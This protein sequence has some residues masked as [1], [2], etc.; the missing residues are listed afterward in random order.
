MNAP[1]SSD[2]PAFQAAAQEN[3]PD[4]AGILRRVFL[5]LAIVAL[6]MMCAAVAINW[7]SVR[8]A[9]VYANAQPVTQVATRYDPSTLHLD[10]SPVELLADQILAFETMTRQG[11]PGQEQQAAEAVYQ[12]LSMNLDALTK[13]T[14]YARVEGTPSQ[15]EAKNRAEGLLAAYS[16]DQKSLLLNGIT[17][18][19]AGYTVDRAAY[20]VVWTSGQYV[21]FVKTF[22]R[23][24][25]PAQKRDFLFRQAEVVTKATDVFQ[26]TGAQGAQSG[27]KK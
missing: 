11:I 1:A 4:A 17:P 21:T 27:S 9:G 23:D 25:P 13:I 6:A 14:V 15:A 20:G 3:A 8:P 7:I 18:A 26:R 5:A 19:K 2:T 10:T 16:V 24:V 12:T 22:F